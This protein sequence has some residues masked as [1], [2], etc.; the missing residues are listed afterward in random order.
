MMDI[1]EY[2]REIWKIPKHMDSSEHDMNIILL[3]GKFYK[4]MRILEKYGHFYGQI[5]CLELRYP[6]VRQQCLALAAFP[7]D[8]NHPKNPMI[9]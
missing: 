3:G 5:T 1:N 8:R 9:S 4:S 6:N 2:L 7:V